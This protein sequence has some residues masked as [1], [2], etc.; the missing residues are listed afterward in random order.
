MLLPL[1]ASKW[2]SGVS[3]LRDLELVLPRIKRLRLIEWMVEMTLKRIICQRDRDPKCLC[4]ALVASISTDCLSVLRLTLWLSESLA[5]FPCLMKFLRLSITGMSFESE[6]RKWRGKRR[7]EREERREGKLKEAGS[8]T[9][10]EFW[11]GL[12][13]RL[14]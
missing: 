6:M 3:N 8:K 1:L 13:V 11:T 10:R 7:R 4:S 9:N 5:A 14:E 12:E 2:S